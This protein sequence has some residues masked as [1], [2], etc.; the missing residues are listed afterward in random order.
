MFLSPKPSL[1]QWL[2][3]PTFHNVLSP[4]ISFFCIHTAWSVYPSLLVKYLILCNISVFLIFAI[5]VCLSLTPRTLESLGS[6]SLHSLG[7]SSL[8]PLT[9]K[10]RRISLSVSIACLV[11]AEPRKTFAMLRVTPQV[12]SSNCYWERWLCPK[13]SLG[14]QGRTPSR[15]A[16][17]SMTS[18]WWDSSWA[19]I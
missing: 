12:L 6:S 16:T 18:L 1:S 5:I 15:R 13:V 3:F 11:L 9:T 17:V 7:S 2:I 4:S 19:V 10:P 14:H 8:H